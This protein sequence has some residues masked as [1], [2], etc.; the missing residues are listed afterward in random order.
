[1]DYKKLVVVAVVL[2]AVGSASILDGIGGIG[3]GGNATGIAI[4]KEK[5]RFD[6]D[7]RVKRDVSYLASDSSKY[8]HVV[9]EFSLISRGS[10]GQT[11]WA[12]AFIRWVWA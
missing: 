2:A 5:K 11:V 1:M 4:L 7:V 8:K 10:A 6:A 12:K 3:F 9:R